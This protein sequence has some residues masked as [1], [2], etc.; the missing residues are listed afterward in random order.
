MED[1]HS[2]EGLKRAI[3]GSEAMNKMS[4]HVHIDGM[5]GNTGHNPDVHVLG[6]I[7]Q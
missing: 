5:W 6:A 1:K 3:L 7:H 2:G 4:E